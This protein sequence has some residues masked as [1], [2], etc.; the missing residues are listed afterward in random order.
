[1][2]YMGS[3]NL[4]WTLVHKGKPTEFKAIA[5]NFVAPLLSVILISN[6]FLEPIPWHWKRASSSQPKREGGNV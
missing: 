5:E 3:A 6:S 2:S 1:M 4:E